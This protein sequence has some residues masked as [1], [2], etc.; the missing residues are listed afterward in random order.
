MIDSRRL[1]YF[2][3]LAEELHF[4][5]AAQRLHLS[6]PSLTQQMQKLESEV[7]VLLLAR[8]RRTVAMTDAGRAFLDRARVVLE[9]MERAVSSAKASAAGKV[10]ELFIGYAAPADL[11]I[12]P[13]LVPRFREKYPDIRLTLRHLGGASLIEALKDDR[14]RVAILRGPIDEPGIETITIARERLVAVVPESHSLA[15]RTRIRFKDFADLPMIFFPR[16]LSP[17]YFD[18]VAQLCL[19]LGGFTLAPSQDVETSQTALALVAAGMGVS[20]QPASIKVLQ[21][22]G[23]RYL[24]IS[25]SPPCAEMALAHRKGDRSKVLDNFLGLV[26]SPA[27]NLGGARVT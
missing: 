16:W 9:E 4:A 10:G 8:N 20:L 2:V 19:E 12:V 15:G 13:Y 14:V 25:D 7:G 27:S 22:K 18:S 11:R 24:D 26:T 6:Q 5:R 1:R 3:T 21:R 17:K 23:V